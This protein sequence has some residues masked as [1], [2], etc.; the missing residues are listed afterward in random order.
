VASSLTFN[1]FYSFFGLRENPFHVSPDPRF[2]YSSPGHD[3]AFSELL[4]GIQTR[5][6]MTVLT[7]EAGSGK[8]MLVNRLLD[9]LRERNLS[10]AYVFHSLLRPSDLFEFIARDFGIPCASSDKG[11]LID[12]LHKWLLRRN[13]AS[14]TPVIIIDEAQALS[15]STLDELRLL[16]NLETAGGKLLHIVLV[17][18]PELDQKLQRHQL[19]QLRQRI[20]FRCRLPLLTW[21]QTGNYIAA[22][23]SAAGASAVESKLFP[24]ETIR[25]LDSYSRGIPR[26]INLLCEHALLAAYSD[27]HHSISPADIH[28]AAAK[29]DLAHDPIPVEEIFPMSTRMALFLSPDPQVAESSVPAESQQSV[30]PARTQD[31]QQVE[32]QIPQQHTEILPIFPVPAPVPMTTEILALTPQSAGE[33][34]PIGDPPAT[35]VPPVPSE[36]PVPIS[37]PNPPVQDIAAEMPTP[38]MNSAIVNSVPDSAPAISATANAVPA[39]VAPA[40]PTAEAN[41]SLPAVSTARKAVFGP[42]RM[43]T[44]MER[45]AAAP[46]STAPTPV[47][48]MPSQVMASNA[49]TPPNPVASAEKVIAPEKVVSSR[50]ITAP[51]QAQLESVAPS[52]S[53]NLMEP[54]VEHENSHRLTAVPAKVS[55]AL[56]KAA[57]PVSQISLQL[58]A[59]SEQLAAASRQV[60]AASKQIAVASKQLASASKRIIPPNFG[61]SI[62]RYCSGVADSFVRDLRLWIKPSNGTNRATA[63]ASAA[64]PESRESAVHSAPTDRSQNVHPESSAASPSTVVSISKWLREPMAPSLQAHVNPNSSRKARRARQ[65]NKQTPRSAHKS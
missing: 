52:A 28:A 42:K 53:S 57:K 18:Q 6:G 2:Y 21:E 30:Q 12:T 60:V 22:R 65:A 48:S 29:F 44:A 26:V 35:D 8:T 38:L 37:E 4:Y 3:T 59:A 61:V 17:G 64:A 63:Q 50:E 40:N 36:P 47:A 51:K 43:A 39:N 5:K 15:S 32:Q 9:W 7:G 13:A 56:K 14:D 24:R 58:A 45:Q 20:M 27:R 23:L 62:V 41:P 19:R 11:A 46:N 25:V 55:P 49:V 31:T 1:Q 54:R 16:L 34:E 33:P 10:S